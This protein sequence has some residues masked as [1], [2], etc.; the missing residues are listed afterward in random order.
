MTTPIVAMPLADAA[1]RSGLSVRELQVAI[2]DGDL[3]AHYRGRKPL[4]RLEDLQD[5]IDNL[6]TSKPA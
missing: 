5:F 6:P 2:R 4:I 3:V 1:T